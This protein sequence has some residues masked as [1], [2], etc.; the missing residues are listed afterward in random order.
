M[1]GKLERNDPPA[2]PSRHLVHRQAIGGHRI[3]HPHEAD[4]FG[5]AIVALV[6]L[7]REEEVANGPVPVLWMPG[8]Q[9]MVALGA[10]LPVGRDG[11]LV[12]L[13]FV[14][15][16]HK[17][18]VENQADDDA[19]RKCAAAE[20]EAVEVVA[21]VLVVAACKFVDVDDVPFQAK[22]ER[23]AKDRPRLECRSADAVVVE[24]DMVVSRKVQRLKGAR[25]GRTQQIAA[26]C[27]LEIEADR[28][29]F[30]N[31]AALGG[32]VFE[33]APGV[34][35]RRLVRRA[36]HAAPPAKAPRRWRQRS[37]A[38]RTANGP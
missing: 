19:D 36:R 12:E 22:A 4:V 26:V 33:I 25:A 29:R 23:A 17:A 35:Q 31:R 37:T 3:P 10:V 18:L 7:D 1:I 27:R 5:L 14:V 32:N 24:G 8:Q 38:A 11:L 30:S 9:S 6:V 15:G 21:F 16:G 34:G 20:A 2:D 28:L 13:A